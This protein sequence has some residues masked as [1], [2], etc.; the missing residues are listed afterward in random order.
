MT[1][2]S[3]K[4]GNIQGWRPDRLCKSVAEAAD[5]PYSHVF[6]ATKA[7]PEVAKTTDLLAPMLRAPYTD[8]YS[9]PTYIVLQ[10]GLGVERDLYQQVKQ[11]GKGEPTVV[12]TALRIGTNLGA[13]NEVIH[14]FP[15]IISLGMY[16][17]DDMATL[18]NTAEEASILGEVRE[19]LSAGGTDTTIVPQIQWAKFQ[20]NFWNVAFS[21]TAT[22]SGY[23][24][25]AL[26]RPPPTRETGPYEPYVFPITADKIS[27]YTLPNVKGL[28]LEMLAL[29]RAMG[30]PDSNE[31]IPSS[32]VDSVLEFTINEHKRPD[33]VHKASMLL[34]MENGLPMEVEPIFG[35]VVRLA[36]QYKVDIPRIQMV[37]ALLLVKQNQ[38]LRLR[39]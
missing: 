38:I 28:L 25:P 18:E 37:Y 20:K 22:L 5:R 34:D 2:R 1:F 3:I 35:E 10:N 23:P 11:V 39:G 13:S 4:Y 12:G 36:E 6:I 33:N 15:A 21:S 30:I 16:R 17:L 9:Q 19:M 24:L 14:S 32:F 8:R 31:G 29:G 7:V 27:T 26:C